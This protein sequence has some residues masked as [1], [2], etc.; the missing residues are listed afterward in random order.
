MKNLIKRSN[1]EPVVTTDVVA[2]EFGRDHFRVMNSIDDLIASEHLGA[3]DFRA[4][5]YVSKQKKVIPCYEL[6]ERG[7][8]IA[9]P[10]IGGDK[11][12]DGQVKLVD[13]FMRMREVIKRDAAI[14]AQRDVARMEYRPMTDAIKRSKEEEGKVPAHYHFSN[15]A[16][17]I[18]RIILGMPSSKF[19]KENEI[20]KDEP[21]RDYLT[22][23]QIRGITELQRADTV[24]LAMGWEFEQRKSGLVS[25]YE[26]NQ[27]LP[28]IEEQHR[29]GA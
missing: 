28:L 5:S 1:G 12:K 10:F 8:L 21:I 27:L 4:S 9:M 3:S 25:L 6:T 18:N 15:E 7:F 24:Y 20:G 19:R 17:M 2:K 29:L 13:S 16:D 11:A 14:K 26:R 22:A 23:E